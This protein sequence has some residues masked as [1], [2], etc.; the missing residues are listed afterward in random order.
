[1]ITEAERSMTTTH[2]AKPLPIKDAE[3]APYWDSLKAHAMRLQR[4]ANGH[5]RYPVNPVCPECLS[6]NFTWE[7][8]SGRGRVYSFIVVHQV[9]DPSFKED[10]P[11]NVAVVE[12]EE[13][14]RLL[15]NLVE[16]DNGDV[17]IDMPVQVV[18]DDVTDEFTLA[19]FAPAP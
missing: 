15:T 4:C 9:Y 17:R 18:Y 8:V 19:R 16:M 10:V 6:T 3:N 7:P 12:L 1:V 5:F 11:Y 14:P 13:G 2:Y